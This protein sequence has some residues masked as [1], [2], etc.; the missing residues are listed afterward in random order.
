MTSRSCQTQDCG[1]LTGKVST[2]PSDWSIRPC[3][4]VPCVM[5][6][7]RDE[8]IQPLICRLSAMIFGCRVV[9]LMDT[10]VWKFDRLAPFAVQRKVQPLPGPTSGLKINTTFRL[11]TSRP[12]FSFQ[13]HLPDAERGRSRVM[14]LSFEGQKQSASS[15]ELKK[16]KNPVHPH[17]QIRL[18]IKPIIPVVSSARTSHVHAGSV[19]HPGEKNQPTLQLP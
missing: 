10:P 15:S 3:L 19:Q 8:W 12:S 1:V 5:I 6:W 13:L 17:H 11:R 4:F 2:A 16:K 14:M 18:L 7:D 9:C